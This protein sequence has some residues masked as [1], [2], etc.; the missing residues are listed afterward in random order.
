MK[1][2]MMM[3]K[4]KIKLKMQETELPHRKLQHTRK[5]IARVNEGY[6]NNERG[7]EKKKR[8][9]VTKHLTAT[10]SNTFVEARSLFQTNKILRYVRER[11]YVCVRERKSARERVSEKEGYVCIVCFCVTFIPRLMD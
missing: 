9:K 5:T 2:K 11:R 7:K 3:M 4:K 6:I 10:F 8:K 1:K